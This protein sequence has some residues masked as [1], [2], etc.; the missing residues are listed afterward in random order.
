[1]KKF[2]LLL[3]LAL[4]I[5]IGGLG[6]ASSVFAQGSASSANRNTA[7]RCLKLAENCL[8]AKDWSNALKQADLGL[9]YDDSISDLIYVKAAAQINQGKTKAYVLE[10][11]QEAFEKN[12]WVAYNKSGARILYADLLSDTG[13]YSRSMSVLD[14]N[15]LIYSADAEFIRIKNL[16]RMG[17]EE[18]INNARLKLNTARRVYPDDIRFPRIFF[19]FEYMYMDYKELAGQV[20]EIPEIVATIANFYIQKLPDYSFKHEELEL[21]AAFFAQGEEQIRLVKAIEAK[22]SLEHPLLSILA[23]KT[24]LYTD[25]QAYESFFNACG[26]NISL[27]CLDTLISNISDAE[28]KKNLIEKLLNFQGKIYIDDNFDLQEELEISY[29][30]GRPKYINYDKNNDGLT[31]VSVSCDFGAPLMIHFDQNKSDVFYDSYPSVNKVSFLTENYDFNFLQGEFNFEPFELK[32]DPVINSL[33]ID[34]YLAEFNQ[35]YQ[36]PLAED[37]ILRTSSVSLPIKERSGA[38]VKYNTMDGNLVYANFYDGDYR[39]AYC[40]F[41]GDLPIIRYVDYDNDSFFE[42]TEYYSIAQDDSLYDEQA[43]E[44]IFGSVLD[45]YKLYLQKVMID[46]NGNTFPEFSESY[47]ENGGKVTLWDNDD[48]GVWDC[49]FIRH[50][51]KKGESSTGIDNLIEETI[52]FDTNGLPLISLTVI[53]SIPVKM[54]YKDEEV[55]IYAGQTDNLY[56]IDEA[57]SLEMENEILNSKQISPLQGTINLVE[58]N[59]KRIWVIKVGYDYFC[60]ILPDSQLSSVSEELGDGAAE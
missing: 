45:D 26:D 14:S 44:K 27:S 9:T 54:L 46:R 38:Y 30:T 7:L 10:L 57:G 60:K 25:A 1:M 21:Y 20:Y 17:G 47:L 6:K 43:I 37:M 59:D 56:W 19:M 11:V 41:T 53:D 48:N 8:L 2:I 51:Q 16:Y 58:Y 18:S 28:V 22:H 42:T 52:F 35:S 15:P 50:P 23:L 32:P 4:S 33:G 36:V 49:Q 29:E 31:D 39:Y 40:D 24:G 12:N 5:E 55:M 34:F 13:L 3:L